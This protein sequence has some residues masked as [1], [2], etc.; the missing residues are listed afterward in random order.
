[1]RTAHAVSTGIRDVRVPSALI[2]VVLAAA[3][4]PSPAGRDL[5]RAVDSRSARPPTT[6]GSSSPPSPSGASPPSPTRRF[7]RP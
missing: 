7:A 1:M 3:T 4:T 5:L 6:A 2:L